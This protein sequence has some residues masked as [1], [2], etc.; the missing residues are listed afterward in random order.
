MTCDDI[1]DRLLALPDPG[2][3]PL[4]LRPHLADCGRCRA[5]LAAV[6][7]VDSLVA[8][9]PVPAGAAKAA[10]LA[11]FDE[12]PP[13]IVLA[14][15]PR[16]P[17]RLRWQHAAGLAAGVCL[18]VGGWI[19]SRPGPVVVRVGPRHDL[20]QKEVRHVVALTK[21]ETATDRMGIWADAA[22][23]FQGEMKVLHQVAAEYDLDALAKMFGRV[24]DDGVVAQARKLP[25]FL[26]PQ[27]R[28][29]KLT[30]AGDKLAAVEADAAALAGTARP[31]AKQYLE[32][33]VRTAKAGKETL[34]K[35]ADGEK[36]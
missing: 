16:R 19:A 36:A 27:E 2:R 34:K 9:L 11:R 17:S 21:A 10:F 26:N 31:A 8:R 25:P 3:L 5:A 24:V 13:I 4:D 18:A 15:A 7:E 32:R 23:D 22:T 33:M 29:E 28:R 30:A 20:L 6:A 12:P 14:P 35:L 1:R